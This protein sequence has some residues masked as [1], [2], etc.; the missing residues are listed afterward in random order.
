MKD[1][2]DTLQ[3]MKLSHD[4]QRWEYIVRTNIDRSTLT[5]LGEEGWELVAVDR[6]G[7]WVYFYFKRQVWWE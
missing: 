1:V 5:P 3:N 4:I 2:M 6:A 7:D